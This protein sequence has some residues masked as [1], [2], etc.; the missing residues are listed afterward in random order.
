M[1]ATF[2]GNI[3]SK[4]KPK[5]MTVGYTKSKAVKKRS[6]DTGAVSAATTTMPATP[7]PASCPVS[8]NKKVK[9]THASD[10]DDNNNVSTVNSNSDSSATKDHNKAVA[11]DLSCSVSVSQRLGAS[12]DRFSQQGTTLPTQVRGDGGGMILSALRSST[13]STG[14][15][16]ESALDLLGAGYP[17]AEV[18]AIFGILPQQVKELRDVLLTNTPVTTISDVMPH[19]IPKLATAALTRVSGVI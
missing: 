16:L 1:T 12:T 7:S 2:F 5:D 6:F 19:A 4:N 15:M 3:A 18:Q 10:N 14:I 9:V 8:Q 17:F 11:R 13:S